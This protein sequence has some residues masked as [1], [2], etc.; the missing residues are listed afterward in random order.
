MRTQ[1]AR[2]ADPEKNPSGEHRCWASM[3]NPDDELW[4]ISRELLQ[5]DAV[6]FFG[7]VRLGTNEQF[8]PEAD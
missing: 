8:L 3:N 7:S 2:L 1:E 6:L 5:S 4:R